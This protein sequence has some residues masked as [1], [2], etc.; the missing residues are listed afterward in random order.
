MVD[1]LTRR[2]FIN[3]HGCWLW[4]GACNDFDYGII[5]IDKKLKYVH[6]VAWELF[7]GAIPRGLCVL[8]DCDSFYPP[9]DRTNRRCFNFEHLF[10]G[11]CAE[12]LKDMVVKGRQAVPTALSMPGSQNGNSRLTE[13][14]VVEIKTRL[15]N[16]TNKSAIARDYGVSPGLISKISRGL[17]W[18]H[19]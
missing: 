15:Q 12:N 3:E 17:I 8:H 11:T 13:A 1:R 19:V 18:N 5:T 10:L 9:G 4:T 14:Q 7:K 16:E 2:R 6:R